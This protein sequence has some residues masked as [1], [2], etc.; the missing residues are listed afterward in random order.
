MVEEGIQKTED[1]AIESDD[2]ATWKSH[3]AYAE[4]F[5]GTDAEYCRRN[6]LNPRQFK[7]YKGKYGKIRMRRRRSKAFAEVELE[8]SAPTRTRDIG[9][10]QAR[11]LPDPR[12]MAEFTKALLDR[13]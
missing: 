8:E 12:W 2:E 4:S 9:S 10:V 1:A 7:F 13:Q 3:I 6:K 5:M 11:E